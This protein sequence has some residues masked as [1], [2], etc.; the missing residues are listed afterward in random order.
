M[1]SDEI[2]DEENQ[3]IEDQKKN[4]RLEQ[5]EQEGNDPAITS[6]GFNDEADNGEF[7]ESKQNIYQ[8][9]KPS[10]DG[11]N[12]KKLRTRKK[13]EPFGDD[14]LG[15]KYYDNI[16]TLDKEVGYDGNKKKHL[17]RKMKRAE[18][19]LGKAL[20][21]DIN[22][23]TVLKEVDLTNLKEYFSKSDIIEED[24]IEKDEIM[25]NKK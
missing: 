11:R 20:G 16:L 19:V 3:V 10:E 21:K 12:G 22:Q 7:G 14:P 6:Q 2:S 24:D 9:V 17:N 1:T 13:D 8:P 23:K 4:Y 15:Q 18:S 25:L 5:I